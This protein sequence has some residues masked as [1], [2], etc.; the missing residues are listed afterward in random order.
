MSNAA[1]GNQKVTNLLFLHAQT[2]LHPG[3]G[4]ALGTVDLP[5]QRERH[6][7]WPVIPGSTLKGI[8]RDMCREKAK[9]N[10]KYQ[11]QTDEHGRRRTRR[12][13][14][15]EEDEE[16]VACFGPGEIGDNTGHAGALSLTDARILAF[17][18][19]SL[20]GVFAWVTCR[21]VLQRLERDLRLAGAT[22]AFET[23]AAWP[24]REQGLCP[25]TSP[26]LIEGDK[27]VL[28]EFEFSRIDQADAVACWVAHHATEDDPTRELLKSNLVVLHDDDFTHFVRHSTEVVARIGLNYENKTVKQG[29]LFYQEFLPT[30]TLFYSLVFANG[31]RGGKVQN[32]AQVM[33]YLTRNLERVLQIGAD[34]TTGKGLCAVRLSRGKETTR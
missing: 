15:N 33:D 8:L 32:A 4:T 34:E 20:C 26:L 9:D 2:S 22:D 13:R 6:T 12:Q 28:E 1:T 18:V 17:P 14:A 11:E 31:S 5:V 24:D 16:L 27:L 29:A 19:R 7:M 21:A 23:P 30:E 25:A 3:A 10:D